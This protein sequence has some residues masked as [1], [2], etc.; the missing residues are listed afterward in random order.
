MTF[1]LIKKEFFAAKGRG[2]YEFLS[3]TDIKPYKNGIYVL[4][5]KNKKFFI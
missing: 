5:S 1:H 2:K 3:F 4:D